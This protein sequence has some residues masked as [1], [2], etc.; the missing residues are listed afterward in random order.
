MNAREQALMFAVT[1]RLRPLAQELVVEGWR[2]ELVV[3]T[4]DEIER[5]PG[6]KI[7]LVVPLDPAPEELAE[8]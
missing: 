5:I 6:F 1:D 2:P 8:R 7:A 4:G 3:L